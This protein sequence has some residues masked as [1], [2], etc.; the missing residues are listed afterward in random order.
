MH[1]LTYRQLITQ[2]VEFN[3]RF[4]QLDI[5][6]QPATFTDPRD[7]NSHYNITNLVREDDGHFSMYQIDL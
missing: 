4:P 6:D 3:K 5:L 2:I 1:N 7:N